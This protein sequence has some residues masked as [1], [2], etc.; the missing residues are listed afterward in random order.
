MISDSDTH[1][2]FGVKIG[3][4]LTHIIYDVFSLVLFEL[5]HFKGYIH[6]LSNSFIQKTASKNWKFVGN[7]VSNSFLQYLF[8]HINA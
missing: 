5:V 3:S 2:I 8:I 4:K 7:K 1:T 6:T